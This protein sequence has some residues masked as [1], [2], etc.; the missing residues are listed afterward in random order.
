MDQREKN[1]LKWF[2]TF[3]KGQSNKV[4]YISGTYNKE[5]SYS[6]NKNGLLMRVCVRVFVA[7][8]HPCLSSTNRTVSSMHYSHSLTHTDRIA[9]V[10]EESSV[11][12]FCRGVCR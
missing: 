12:Q 9:T 2:R 5:G 11:A 1:G 8:Y 3:C 6:S 7:R 4:T 10:E